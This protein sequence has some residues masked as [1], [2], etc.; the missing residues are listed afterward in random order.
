MSSKKTEVRA[1]DTKAYVNRLF[2]PLNHSNVVGNLGQL[3][4]DVA[5]ALQ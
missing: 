5:S 3:L 4:A 1:E 2:H